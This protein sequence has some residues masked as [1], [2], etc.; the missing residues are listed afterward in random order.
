MFYGNRD[1]MQHFTV[2][3]SSYILFRDKLSVHHRVEGLWNIVEKGF[4]EPDDES[5]LSEAK[6]KKIE[7]SRRQDARALSK[8]QIGVTKPIFTRISRASTTKEAWEILEGEFHGDDKVRSIN[9]QS[10]KKDFQNLRM[11]DSENTQSYNARVMEIV[12]QMKILGDDITDQHVVEKILISLTDKYEYIVAVI[13]E[14]KDLSKLLIRELMGSLQAHEKRR[15]KQA[16]QSE[17]AFLSRAKVKPQQF[18]KKGGYNQEQKK[19]DWRKN[20]TNTYKN[21][22]NEREDLVILKKTADLKIVRGQISQKKRRTT[23]KN[24]F[25]MLVIP[26]FM[27]TTKH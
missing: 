26:A 6:L 5:D 24:K 27:K 19:A 18:S 22:K 3:N 15:L 25:F 2:T 16:E 4:V 7:T 8:L 12:N 1:N 21:D 11:K 9:L 14:T 17:N 13:E 10:L 20:T 23:K